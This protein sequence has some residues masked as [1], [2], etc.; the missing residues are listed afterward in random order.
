M[1]TSNPDSAE[2]RKAAALEAL[3]AQQNQP[4]EDAANDDPFGR[5]QAAADAEPEL[6]SDDEPERVRDDEPEGDGARDFLEQMAQQEKEI[7]P[8][9]SQ[10]RSLVGGGVSVADDPLVTP[11]PDLAGTQATPFVAPAKRAALLQANARR[12][13]KNSFKQFMIPLLIIV[14]G[15]LILMSVVTM[16]MLAGDGG[17]M[18][19]MAADGTYL[20]AYG[21]Y[22]IIASLP[23]GAILIM[24]AWLFFLDTRKAASRK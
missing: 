21:K 15:L 23:I 5:L 14:G 22:F 12:M 24:G 18:D 11:A 2:Q 7:S 20:R 19:A 13:H 17:D 8:E 10:L 3:A 9:L 16:I 4:P 6:I 1:N